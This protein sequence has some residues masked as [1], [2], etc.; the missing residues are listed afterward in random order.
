VSTLGSVRRFY[1]AKRHAAA[2]I[3]DHALEAVWRGKQ[4]AEAGTDLPASF[5]FLT[6]LEALGYT[7]EEDLDGADACE[8]TDLG[9]GAFEAE[10][11]LA[12]FA[13]LP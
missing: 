11:V 2:E 5:P 6:E 7:T 9:L 12:A 1:L 13:E 10:A 8:L 4:E 3:E